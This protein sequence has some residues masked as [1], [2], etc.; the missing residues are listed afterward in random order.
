[1]VREL[2]L[3]VAAFLL[4][5]SAAAAAG[6]ALT[7]YA[8]RRANRV[9]PDRRSHAPLTWLWSL[10]EPARLHRRLRRAVQSCC[11]SVAT[12]A[13]TLRSL[14]DE[15]AGRAGRID[16][17]LAATSHI[18]WAWRGPLMARLSEAVREIER[19]ALQLNRLATEWRTG[20]HQVA[21]SESQPDL[22]LGSR[23]AAAHAALAEVTAAS[24]NYSTAA[25]RQ[26]SSAP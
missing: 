21:L 15:V 17:E 1:V 4:A 10:R 8:L 19:S 3:F 13:P 9:S 23:M 26:F 11:L 7:V 6:C 24:R 5:V 18:R 14:A 22:D 16:D 25:S 20:L 2:F 12:G